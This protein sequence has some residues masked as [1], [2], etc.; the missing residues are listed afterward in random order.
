MICF[1]VSGIQLSV[2]I[3][4][5]A[6]QYSPEIAP[7]IKKGQPSSID[8]LRIGTSEQHSIRIS[9][10]NRIGTSEQHSE[11]E[12]STILK[13]S[14]RYKLKGE[15]LSMFDEPT[16]L[17][18]SNIS[19]IGTTLT[20]RKHKE[21]GYS[22][23]SVVKNVITERKDKFSDNV[24][25]KMSSLLK[26]INQEQN[27][28][29]DDMEKRQENSKRLSSAVQTDRKSSD[30]TVSIRPVPT[31][32]TYRG[33]SM[34]SSKLLSSSYS[35]REPVKC[36]ETELVK[37]ANKTNV[38]DSKERNFL[39]RLCQYDGSP[40]KAKASETCRLSGKKAESSERTF[41]IKKNISS[42]MPMGNQEKNSPDLKRK[43][44][45]KIS[46]RNNEYKVFDKQKSCEAFTSQRFTASTTVN[47]PSVK[48]GANVDNK[49]G[50]THIISS[51]ETKSYKNNW[52][53]SPESDK[54][55]Y[56]DVTATSFDEVSDIKSKKST[57]K[58]RSDLILSEGR[59][60]VTKGSLSSSMEGQKTSAC[61]HF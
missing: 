19:T 28:V 21:T 59:T 15:N 5:Q 18:P 29:E 12:E 57:A 47:S 51:S 43:T 60:S 16:Q 37:R 23:M 30:S 44:T 53:K 22:D 1:S 7:D 10:Y 39:E 6:Y 42:S 26:A 3:S 46:Q 13:P 50:S 36:E 45:N 38:I 2:P 58:V 32:G 52:K 48:N 11:L 33:E 14:P 49:L 31:Y 41:T 40:S 55:A 9:E 25:E 17:F 24:K 54:V 20:N 27:L 34:A 61:R 35:F 8:L 4:K 56:Y